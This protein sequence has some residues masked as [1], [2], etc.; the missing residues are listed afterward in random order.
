MTDNF[1]KVLHFPNAV[2]DRI[3]GQVML[4]EESSDLNEVAMAVKSEEGVYSVM[5]FPPPAGHVAWEVA[6][7][8]HLERLGLYLVQLAALMRLEQAGVKP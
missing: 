3:V 7:A 1:G 5:L 2:R 6:E 8:E 4:I